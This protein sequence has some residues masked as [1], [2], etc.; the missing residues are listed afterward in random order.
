MYTSSV[1]AHSPALPFLPPPFW[2]APRPLRETPCKV[3]IHLYSRCSPRPVRNT[4]NERGVIVL[5]IAAGQQHK[6]LYD[7]E[8]ERD[9]RWTPMALTIQDQRTEQRLH[10]RLDME[11]PLLSI[12]LA[13]ARPRTL[14]FQQG[15]AGLLLDEMPLEDIRAAASITLQ[16]PALA[17][18]GP[19]ILAGLDLV[20]ILCIF[21]QS[22][23]ECYT[24]RWPAGSCR[25]FHMFVAAMVVERA[26]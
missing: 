6:L 5:S 13:D 12:G 2:A 22:R 4:V 16:S 18:A 8:V 11:L 1:Q 19:E 24:L 7:I 21:Q 17:A 20:G 10:C 9:P 23:P 26:S 3:R 25:A 14:T 15:G